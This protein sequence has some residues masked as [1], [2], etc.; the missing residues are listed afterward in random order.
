MTRTTARRSL[1]AI[2]ADIE[3][4]RRDI[5][6]AGS[7]LGL[8]RAAWTHLRALIDERDFREAE[9]AAS[10]AARALRAARREP[11][12]DAIEFGTRRM[13][14]G[15]FRIVNLRT[16]GLSRHRYSTRARAR[17]AISSAITAE[18]LS[19]PAS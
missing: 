12:A 16:G 15:T 3:E 18:R 2:N 13:G 8:Y 5:A 19:R 7:N 6:T 10:R 1:R 17:A 9:L 4:A 14:D 11:V